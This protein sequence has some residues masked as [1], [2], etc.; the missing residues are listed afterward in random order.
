[1]RKV[2]Y[3]LFLALS[4]NGLIAQGSYSGIWKTIDDED[5]TANSHVEIYTEDGVLKGKI[6]EVLKEGGITHCTKCKGERKD[7]AILG[8]E[9]IWGMK[10]DGDRYKGGKILDPRKGKIYECKL[11]LVEEDVLEVRGYFKSPVFGRTQRWY[12]VKG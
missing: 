11:E 12:R 8:M 10:K 2:L 4:A 7:Q 1:M 3:I 9:F 6:V 5:G